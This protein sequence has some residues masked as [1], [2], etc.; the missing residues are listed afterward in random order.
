M[1]NT[2]DFLDVTPTPRILRILGE[3]PFQPWQCIAELI[4]NAIDAFLQAESAGIESN[5]A[6]IIV[7]WSNSA[8]K[9]SD[10]SLEVIDN[11]S[12]MSISQ[13]NN[14]VRA[15]FSSNDP[16]HNL[17]LFGM[18]FNIATARLGE[19]TEIVSTKS[20]ESTWQGVKI[21]FSQMIN[22][23]SFNAPIVNR[24]K[25]DIDE[26]GTH[27]TITELKSGI[28]ESLI[29]REN[30][31]RRQLETIYTPLLNSHNITIIVKGK[32]LFPRN[33]CVWSSN[34]YVVRDNT[35]IPAQILIDRDF[36]EAY[37]DV[38]RNRYCT[39]DETDS[40]EKMVATGQELPEGIILRSKR[41]TGWIGIQRYSD[42]DDF[43]IDFIRNGRKILISDKSLFQYENLLTGTKN[44]QYPI[45]LGS[46]L[47]GRIIGEINVD[48]L[49]PTYQKNDF[50]RNDYSWSQAVE[51]L[52]GLGPYLPQQRKAL[53]FTED[54]T[55]PIPVL[56][57]A[58]RRSD[59]GTKCLAA[60]NQLAKQYA[61][62]FRAGK[63]EYIS[64]DIWWKAAQEEDQKK[65]TGG[66]SLTTAVNSGDED[67]DDISAYFGGS[68]Q[69]PATKVNTQKPQGTTAS[70]PATPPVTSSKLDDLLQN[71]IAVTQLSNKY[72][73][74][75]T[76]PLTVYAYELKSGEILKDDI[77]CP[78]YFQ[79]TGID[80]TFIYNPRH[81]ILAQYPITPKMLLLL[82]LSEKFKARDAQSDITS[83]YS[84]LLKNTMSETKID[85]YSLQEKASD[86]FTRLRAGIYN[87][88]S[89]R[90]QDVLNCIHESSGEVEETI[91]SLLSNGELLIAFQSKSEKGFDAVESV[92]ERTLIRI[93]DKYPESVFDGKVFK[94][95]Y[96]SISFSD[97]KA[98][99]RSRIES[100]DRIMSF[101]KDALRITTNTISQ[102]GQKNELAR[103]SI[104]IDFLLDELV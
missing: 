91:K 80:C 33:H 79:S 23:G 29:H 8:V 90:K 16:V 31:I 41:M 59:A 9:D 53:G 86:V 27:V 58:Y 87:A 50:D 65:A 68:G 62:L 55:A 54:V 1:A 81:E 10:F 88:L 97:E 52:C 85:K 104:S 48:F 66:A 34:R 96:L 71:S 2:P 20:G 74:S 83:V 22:T 6:K 25:K 14:A 99:E 56:V 92:P 17:G 61:Q 51:A 37:F 98:T 12:G 13:I 76:S 42:P 35:N 69:T 94:A 102:A 73:Y 100:K 11:A 30:D 28:R 5:D 36:G 24:D 7:S 89:D 3:I 4:D 77:S 46:T 49:L 45:E 15:G 21:D 57:N 93:V 67:S 70:S 101:L 78:C 103:A 75:T 26:H 95:P 32:Q 38:T 72:F 60:P 18:G 19:H 39:L 63:S 40:Y 84:S 43:G 82:Y 47:G 44:I 64:D